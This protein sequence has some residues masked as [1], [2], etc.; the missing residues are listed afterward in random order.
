M[1][2]IK[3]RWIHLLKTIQSTEL[4]NRGWHL[5]DVAEN[6]N[7]VLNQAEEQI[8]F[9]SFLNITVSPPDDLVYSF[10]RALKKSAALWVDAY[11]ETWCQM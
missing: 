6:D 1:F 2:S 7:I 5:S 10:H 4:V 11:Y 9:K 3:E 8:P